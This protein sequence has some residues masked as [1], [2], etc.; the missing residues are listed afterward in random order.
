MRL[1]GDAMYEWAVNGTMK[2]IGFREGSS[3]IF[4]GS[5]EGLYQGYRFASTEPDEQTFTVEVPH[6]TLGLVL[7]QEIV[8]ALPPRPDEHPFAEGKDPL[9]E[10]GSGGGPPRGDTGGK[11]PWEKGKALPMVGMVHPEALDGHQQPPIPVARRP[12]STTTRCSSGFT[13]WT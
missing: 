8:S 2:T 12:A 13:T 6:G 7:R 3:G 5:I 1:K 10:A 11:L 9:A 4:T